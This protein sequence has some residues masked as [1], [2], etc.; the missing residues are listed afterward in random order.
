MTLVGG[1]REDWG[2]L[3]KIQEEK[4]LEGGDQLYVKMHM[5]MRE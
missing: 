5:K 2:G 3:T 1:K 4:R